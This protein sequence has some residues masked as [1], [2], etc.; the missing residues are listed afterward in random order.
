[1]K[2]AHRRIGKDAGLPEDVMDAILERR[3]PNLPDARERA[4]YELAA[5]L[6][7]N[8]VVPQEAAERAQ[9]VLGNK[10]IAEVIAFIASYAGAA[11][12]MRF[13]DGKPPANAG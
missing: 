3:V 12:T 7:H 4:F 5:A 9:K 10:A 1:V 13:V 8:L 6:H 2:W 11:Y